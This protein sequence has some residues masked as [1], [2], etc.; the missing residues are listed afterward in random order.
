MSPPRTV[1]YVFD[2]TDPAASDSQ[3]EIGVSGSRC[4]N[5]HGH[6]KKTVTLNQLVRTQKPILLTHMR[7]VC[8]QEG[9]HW[10]QTCSPNRTRSYKQGFGAFGSISDSPQP[11]IPSPKASFHGLNPAHRV[12]IQNNP[13]S[14]V[15]V[16]LCRSLEHIGTIISCAT[17]CWT[18]SS[19]SELC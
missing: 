2:E 19:Q 1:S 8:L 12:G 6:Y 17:E 15:I 3:C 18:P 5:T 7:T 14:G 11:Y 16:S 10:G 9:C 13:N 4:F